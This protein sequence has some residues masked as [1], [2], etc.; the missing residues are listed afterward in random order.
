MNVLKFGYTKLSILQIVA[1]RLIN[2]RN[3]SDIVL[4]L[5]MVNRLT[6]RP[7]GTDVCLMSVVY[8]QLE[9]SAT[10]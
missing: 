6:V 10:D 4:H 5:I 9:V 7:A 1:K 3:K 8:C 2:Y